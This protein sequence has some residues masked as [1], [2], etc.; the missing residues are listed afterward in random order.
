MPYPDGLW[1]SFIRSAPSPFPDDGV[2]IIN[3]L[4]GQDFTGY[5]YRPPDTTPIEGKFTPATG[6]AADH[7][8]FA[9]TY[10]GVTYEYYADIFQLTPNYYVTN[11]GKRRT[12]VPVAVEEDWVGTH[13]T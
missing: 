3:P 11:N 4:N 8:E 10:N 5:H 13:T 12:T 9:E 6:D 2:V 7:I 1:L